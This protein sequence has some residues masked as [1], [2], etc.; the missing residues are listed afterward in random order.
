MSDLQNYVVERRVMDGVVV[1]QIDEKD[2]EDPYWMGV[3][4]NSEDPKSEWDFTGRPQSTPEK[5]KARFLSDRRA[6]AIQIK[7][8]TMSNIHREHAAELVKIAKR[9]ASSNPRLSRQLNAAAL[10][11]AVNNM[12]TIQNYVGMITEDL[13][14]EDESAALK[15]IKE[16]A[17]TVGR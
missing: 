4:E 14:N 17:A 16:L 5:A 10:K 1:V 6:S 11:M 7:K 2:G 12:V 13:E 15:H 3:V 9:I 8:A